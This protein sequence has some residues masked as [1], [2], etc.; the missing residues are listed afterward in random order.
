MKKSIILLLIGLIIVIVYISFQTISVTP[1]EK[2]IH[3]KERWG[4]ELP[5][6][7]EIIDVWSTKYPARGDGEW[8]TEFNYDANVSPEQLNDFTKITEENLSKANGYVNF[9][10]NR[11]ISMYS[12]QR[13]EAFKKTIEPYAI[14][15]KPGDYYFHKSE[16]GNFDTFTAIYQQQENR[17]LIFEWHQ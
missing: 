15:L 14:S 13:D 10:L 6:P 1:E 11:V 7:D 3:Y 5:L 16:N 12:I 2:T 8:V 17:I 4:I 9:F